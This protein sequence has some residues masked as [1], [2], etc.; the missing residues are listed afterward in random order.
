M[1]N[2]PVYPDNGQSETDVL[3]MIAAQVANASPWIDGDDQVHQGCFFCEVTKREGA[4]HAADCTWKLAQPWG[5]G[6]KKK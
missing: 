1:T 5:T 6:D 3:R 2:R 4:E